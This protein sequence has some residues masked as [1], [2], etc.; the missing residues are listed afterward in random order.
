MFLWFPAPS[1]RRCA[2]S[3]AHRRN[4]V[5]RP[6]LWQAKHDYTSSKSHSARPIST[7]TR[8]RSK[9][10]KATSSR[11]TAGMSRY[12]YS[13]DSSRENGAKLNSF[14]GNSRTGLSPRRRNRSSE[15]AS[16]EPE[17]PN[18][19]LPCP[20]RLGATSTLI[21][22]GRSCRRLSPRSSSRECERASTIL[23]R[24]AGRLSFGSPPCNGYPGPRQ[25][26]RTKARVGCIAETS[27]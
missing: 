5:A 7:P 12:I 16:R 20:F 23:R 10:F 25:A 13:S 9:I 3:T 14:S 18:C 26:G 8:V 15:N 4:F 27:S 1:Q 19:S 2:C 17:N 11:A 24:I 22:P 6:K 21:F